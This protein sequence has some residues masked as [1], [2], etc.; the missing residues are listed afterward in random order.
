[1][2]IAAAHPFTLRCIIALPAFAILAGVGCRSM[3]P[4]PAAD[5]SVPGWRVRQGQA[6]WKPAKNRPELAG[7]LLLASN[8]DGDFLV[9]FTKIPFP[10]AT[11]QMAGDRWQLE[12]G[13]GDYRRT[14]RG[15]PPARFAW[16]ELPRALAGA[17]IAGNWRFERLS[18]SSWRLENWRTGESLEGYLGP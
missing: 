7:E 11:A 5:L 1:M 18:T 6:V 14:G 10:M 13:S 9:Q 15:K 16:F 3:P 17:R 8:K 12:F 4:L 2:W